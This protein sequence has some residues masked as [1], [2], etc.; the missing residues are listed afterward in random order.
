MQ[1]E[2]LKFLGATERMVALSDAW[3][4]GLFPEGQFCSILQGDGRHDVFFAVAVLR[5]GII[6]WRAHRIGSQFV[7][8]DPP[9]PAWTS[10]SS[11]ATGRRMS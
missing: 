3:V 1:A 5:C 6:G 2:L 11:S 10:T 8:L 7:R 9:P 4:A